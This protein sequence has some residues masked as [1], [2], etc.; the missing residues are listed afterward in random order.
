MTFPRLKLSI[1][2]LFVFAVLTPVIQAQNYGQRNY[3]G[4]FIDFDEFNPNYQFFAPLDNTHFGD[5]T[6]NMGWYFSWD[7][8]SLKTVRPRGEES[9][10]NADDGWG[11]RIEFGFMKPDNMGWSFSTTTLN[12]PNLIPDGNPFTVDDENAPPAF[13]EG[14][15]VRLDANETILDT[16]VEELQ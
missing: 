16:K 9:Y 2:I 6:P 11:K 14:I 4:P 5:F 13:T 12:G 8:L 7:K 10:G 1:L 15:R 3:S